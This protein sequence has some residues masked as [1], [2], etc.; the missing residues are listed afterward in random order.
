MGVSIVYFKA[1]YMYVKYWKW[2][3]VK[4]YT[5][6]VAGVWIWC[7]QQ[8]QIREYDAGEYSAYF[9]PVSTW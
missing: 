1:V 7:W 9:T 8:I 3:L 6:Y 4:N 2:K 5:E